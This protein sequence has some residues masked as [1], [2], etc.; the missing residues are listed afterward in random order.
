MICSTAVFASS[1]KSV[2]L[3]VI[4]NQEG[5]YVIKVPNQEVQQEFQKLTA[6]YLKV[7]GTDLFTMFS[8][9]KRRK[10]EDFKEALILFL[11]HNLIPI[12][13]Y[14]FHCFQNDSHYTLT[15]LHCL[16]TMKSTSSLWGLLVNAGYLTISKVISNQEGLYV[17]K[18][19]N[20]YKFH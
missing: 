3:S 12:M 8:A 9:L 4:S 14:K 19:P 17:I 7:T 15:L 16:M 2:L 11:M 5:L 1:F 18:V 20:H 13:D 10:K 6:H